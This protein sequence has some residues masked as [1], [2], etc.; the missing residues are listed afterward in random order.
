MSLSST[1]ASILLRICSEGYLEKLFNQI[2]HTMKEMSNDYKVDVV[3]SLVNVLKT[4][5]KQ[6]GLVNQF[7][8]SIMQKEDSDQVRREIVEVMG[9]EVTQLGGSAKT[10]CIQELARF[11]SYAKNEKIHFQILGII[12]R[13]AEK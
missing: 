6:Y 12:S 8:L 13:E 2:D 7:L 9:Y 3:R 10:Q 4:Y 11:L 5:P 1:A